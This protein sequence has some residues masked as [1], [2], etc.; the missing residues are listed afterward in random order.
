MPSFKCEGWW[1]SVCGLNFIISAW[2]CFTPLHKYTMCND[3]LSE[4]PGTLPHTVTR[5]T[6]DL[7]DRESTLYISRPGSISTFNIFLPSRRLLGL[8][9]HIAPVTASGILTR[10]SWWWVQS[11]PASN[12]EL[13]NWEI[14]IIINPSIL[15]I[16]NPI[17]LLKYTPGALKDSFGTILHF[18]SIAIRSDIF[19]TT[20]LCG[21]T[22][23][24]TG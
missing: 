17:R 23:S 22:L 21:R 3:Q 16:F 19:L 7:Q 2:L 13:H 9:L 18:S 1:E 10:I 24:K 11:Y 4:W 12:L 8:L 6:L 15:S 14:R 5:S 20:L